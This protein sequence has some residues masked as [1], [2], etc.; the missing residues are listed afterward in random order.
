[1]E[2]KATKARRNPHIHLNITANPNVTKSGYKLKYQFFKKYLNSKEP[3]WVNLTNASEMFGSDRFSD[4]QPY[5]SGKA[6]SLIANKVS[7]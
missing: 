7:G 3:V 2:L 4:R 6:P 5:F 1:M